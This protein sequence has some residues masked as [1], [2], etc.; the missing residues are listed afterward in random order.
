MQ[1]ELCP[2]CGYDIFTLLMGTFK[3]HYTEMPYK[4]S[5]VC[6]EKP[7]RIWYNKRRNK[8]GTKKHGVAISQTMDMLFGSPRPTGIL[9]Q[10]F[11]FFPK[12]KACDA[13][14]HVCTPYGDRR[15]TEN[16]G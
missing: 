16:C 12:V 13:M 2:F 11:K 6:L 3:R 8:T 5:I 15:C 4:N 1:S 9:R 14:A 10:N 7:T